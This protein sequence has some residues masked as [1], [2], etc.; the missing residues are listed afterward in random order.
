MTTTPTTNDP[1]AARGTGDAEPPLLRIENLGVAFPSARGPIHAVRDVTL[2]LLPDALA[3]AMEQM[4]ARGAQAMRSALT[5]PA[6]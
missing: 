6:R 3:P 4:M 1:A 2:S 5:P